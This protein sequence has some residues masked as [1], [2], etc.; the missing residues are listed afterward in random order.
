VSPVLAA[1]AELS[2][3]FAARD[4]AAALSCFVPGDD[5][6]YVG[7]EH[8]EAATGRA[9]VADLFA[10]VFSRDEAYRWQVTTA[11]VREY[12]DSAYVL[13]EADGFAHTDAG[14]V[15]PFAYRIS[16]LLEPSG[17]GWRWRHCHGC[18]PSPG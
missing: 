17:T 3:A 15:I 13:A 16:G 4:A 1:A 10:D 8:T 11:S 12:R 9:A 6:S 14:E 7:S 5:I 18:E 2:A